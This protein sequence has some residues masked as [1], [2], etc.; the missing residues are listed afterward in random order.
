MKNRLI[1]K[2][3]DCVPNHIKPINYLMDTLDLGRESAYR[4][5]RGEIPFTVEEVSKLS[6]ELG[7]SIDET[8]SEKRINKVL[9]DVH[10]EHPEPAE[11]FLSLLR[12]YFSTIQ[13]SEDRN[14]E[15]LAA[16]N[17]LPLSLLIHNEYLFKFYYYKYVHHND[18]LDQH[19]YSD[20]VVPEEIMMYRNEFL[21]RTNR[22]NNF[23]YIVNSRSFFLNICREIQYCYSRR[24]LTSNE[25]NVLQG[26][27]YNMLN[28]IKKVIETGTDERLGNNVFFYLSYTEISAN[29]AYLSS[30]DNIASLFWIYYS[31]FIR[32]HNSEICK[33]HRN[34]FDTM[35]KY[36]ILI[37]QSNEIF[38]SKF[39][40]QQCQQ[41]DNITKDIL[42]M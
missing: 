13:V 35:K 32:I 41:I 18:V 3:T 31:Y 33:M 36:A 12:R 5:L 24:L 4:R 34:W 15:V 1:T 6:L 10:P 37:S 29:G 21:R 2:I 7:F 38:Q 11:R 25:V 22:V 23:Y 19:P 17:R 39:Y 8:V 40:D 9:L 30:G 27:L 42:Y 14:S 28:F 16:Q 20:L 26:A